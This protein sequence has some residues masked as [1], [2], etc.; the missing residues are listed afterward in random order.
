MRAKAQRHNGPMQFKE[1]SVIPH[2]WSAEKGGGERRRTGP[3]PAMTA[4]TVALDSWAQIV[5]QI[6][7]NSWSEGEDLDMHLA[8]P[9]EWLCLLRHQLRAPRWLGWW[10]SCELQ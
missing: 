5:C 8:Q 4:Y 9:S 7:Q 2:G 3:T 6:H 1:L 10:F